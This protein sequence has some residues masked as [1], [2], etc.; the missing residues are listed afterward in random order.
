MAP[1][2]AR[3]SRSK[4]PL[5]RFV[6]EETCSGLECF[7]HRVGTLVVANQ[8]HRRHSIET[9]I[10]HLSSEFRTV[11][12]IHSQT[13]KSNRKFALSQDIW[14]F[15]AAVQT[16]DS[17]PTRMQ[18]FF[19]QLATRGLVIDDEGSLVHL[20]ARFPIPIVRPALRSTGAARS[21]FVAELGSSGIGRTRLSAS[22][23]R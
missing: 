1:C 20:G 18:D 4:D 21:S 8:H 3:T 22:G 10:P 14:C 2:A 11:R 23:S 17:M 9:G 15:R 7:R 19:D 6:E 16:S 13:K 5:N 12:E